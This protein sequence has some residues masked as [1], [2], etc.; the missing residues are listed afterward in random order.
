MH[1]IDLLD[2]IGA[3]VPFIYYPNAF[4]TTSPDE[5]GVVKVTGG[6]SPTQTLSRPSF[7]V[8]I[9]A[10]HPRNAEDKAWEVYE[11]FNLKRGFDVGQTHVIYCNAQQSSPLYIG[12]D[13]N[14]RFLYSVNFE[15]ISEVL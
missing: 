15:T 7:Q 8:V 1:T 5:C 12:T 9:R 4:P 6:G 2:Y 10:K 13:E 3:N 14:G 11:F